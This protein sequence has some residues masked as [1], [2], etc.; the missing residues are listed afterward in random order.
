MRL[1][2]AIA[3]I[4]DVMLRACA[5]CRGVGESGLPQAKKEKEKGN[6][7]QCIHGT[8]VYGILCVGFQG[9]ECGEPNITVAAQGQLNIHNRKFG[10]PFSS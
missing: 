9:L 4:P 5:C 10:R 2:G 7:L 6:Q 1:M 8:Q 3:R